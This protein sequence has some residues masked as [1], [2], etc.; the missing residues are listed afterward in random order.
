MRA[1]VNGQLLTDPQ[2][3]AIA[4]T[5]H[6]LTVGDGV[7]EAIKVVDGRPFALTRHLQRLERSAAALGL[8]APDVE[9]LR[10]AVTDVLAQEQLPLGRIRITYTG[11]PAPLGSGRG[12]AAPTSVVVAAPMDRAPRT[13]AV[14]TVPWPRNERGALAG[15]KSTSYA[16]N[17]V[18]LSEA[19]KHDAS[20]AVFANLAGHLCEGTGTNVGYVVGGE[21]RTPSLGSGCLAGVTRAL[22]LE[23]YDVREV[24]EPIEVLDSAE[25]I[26][27]LSTTR[28]V[29]A[30]HR[31][32]D[33]DLEAPG[34]ITRQLMELWASREA[35]DVDP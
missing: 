1:W 6:G 11:G 8:P 23:W 31:W 32:N 34:P 7:F 29:Q 4:V 5:D 22:L 13:S 26:F 16:E 17:V 33:R 9:R 14:V 21:V 10:G 25:E 19:A 20:E 35:E 3:P 2:S 28:D 30:V 18:A 24:D 12:D 27:L 15:V